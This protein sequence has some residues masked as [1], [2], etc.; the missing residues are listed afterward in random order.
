M[1]KLFIATFLLSFQVFAL[2][3][4]KIADGRY[5]AFENNLIDA[6]QT[7]LILL[8]GV[9]RGLDLRDPVIEM[10]KKS[11]MN[12]VSMHFSLHPESLLL[13]PKNET[14]YFKSHSYKASDLA[15]EVLALIQELK[16]KKPL[17]VGLSYSSAVTTELA[18]SGELPLIV[19]TA[20][21]I[22]YDEGDPSGASVTN[23][24]KSWLQLNPFL[25]AFWID[26]Y[27]KQ[28]YEQYWSGKV[29]AL[30][31]TYPQY[32]KANMR[33]DMIK[34]Y[35]QLSFAVDGFDFLKQDFKSGTKRIFILAENE[36]ENR[37]ALQQKAVELYEKQTGSEKSSTLISGAGHIIPSEQ[38]EAYLNLLNKLS[39]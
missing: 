4:L 7:T 15:D 25:G 27:L 12:F 13:I 1:I 18:A 5:I 17:V 3:G 39:E 36:A 23:F 37:F 26:Y 11:K 22:Q 16:I 9:F 10:A 30:L 21:M 8:P 31:K 2:E 38:P 14:A 33:S 34:A 29:D 32:E 19:E 20:P 28:A 24:W 35:A 6:D